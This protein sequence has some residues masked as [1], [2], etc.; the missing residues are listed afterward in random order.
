VV[1]VNINNIN[2][3]ISFFTFCGTSF[4]G[5]TNVRLGDAILITKT[6][7]LKD[8]AEAEEHA[9]QLRQKKIL[10][11]IDTPIIFGRS[12]IV[13]QAK[14]PKTGLNLPTAVAAKMVEG[15]RVLVVDD[16]PTLVRFC[17]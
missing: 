12:R 7:E 11:A 6:N 10:K 14:D 15:K 2:S 9:R 8:M 5:E 4:P 16:G 3:P 17:L 13:A 1:W